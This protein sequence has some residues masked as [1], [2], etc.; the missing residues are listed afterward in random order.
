MSA[1]ADHLD[2]I[3]PGGAPGRGEGVQRP[4]RR[5]DGHGKGARPPLDGNGE[6]SLA[7]EDLE[8]LDKPEAGQASQDRSGEAEDSPLDDEDPADVPR[9]GP[10]G[11]ED[12]DLALLLDDGYGQD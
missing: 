8:E 2:R 7:R 4:G 11:F 9:P 10:E 1:I 3:E 5:G 12:A 6:A